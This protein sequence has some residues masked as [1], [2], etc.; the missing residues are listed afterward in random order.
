MRK[1]RHRKSDSDSR[2]ETD[3]TQKKILLASNIKGTAS[4]LISD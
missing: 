4:A 1:G 3:T 2:T